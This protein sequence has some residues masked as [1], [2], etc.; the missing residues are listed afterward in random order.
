MLPNPTTPTNFMPG[1]STGTQT[2][3]LAPGPR[4]H[5]VRV[6]VLGRIG[7][8]VAI[9]AI[10]FPRGTEVICRTARG[11]EAGSVVGHSEALSDRGTTDG[12]L[13]RAVSPTDRLL[14]ER[15]DQRRDEA[16]DACTVFLKKAGSSAVLMDVEQIFQGDRIFFYFLGAPPHDLESLLEPLAEAYDS[17]VRFRDF[18]QAVETGCGPGC[19]TD[20]A[21]GCG[22]A[23]STCS[24][25]NAC[26]R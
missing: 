26:R 5:F 13:L 18:V 7:R 17:K 8:F 11:L 10:S 23:C 25:A 3:P 6:G 12:S 21:I 4:E 22:D 2:A 15:L 1:K 20:Q 19:G 9:D 24:V 16:F 14:L